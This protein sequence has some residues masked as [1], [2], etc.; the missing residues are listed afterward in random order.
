MF[1]YPPPLIGMQLHLSFYEMIQKADV[2][3]MGKVVDQQN[4]YGPNHKMIFTDVHFD[5]IDVIY[6]N[7]KSQVSVGEDIILTFAGGKMGEEIVKVSDVPSFETGVTY[8]IFTRMD[9]KTYASPI[10]GAFQGLFKIISDKVTD[11]SYPLTYGGS[12]IV[13]IEDDDL[14][15]GPSVARVQA[16]T[17][18][19]RYD[20]SLFKSNVVPPVPAEGMDQTGACAHVSKVASKM[21]ENIMSLDEF[22]SKINK[23][24]KIRKVE[25]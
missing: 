5:T 2:I 16:G 17:I 20:K 18:E 6:S 11:I 14:I 12:C 8:I 19:K 21:P 3:F 7:K 9:G 24:L 23:H 25:K 1:Y 15:T 13:R 22:I 10:I 4:R